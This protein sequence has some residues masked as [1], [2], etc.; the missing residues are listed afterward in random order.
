MFLRRT[1]ITNNNSK[2]FLYEAYK[3]SIK[4]GYIEE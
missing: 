1:N 3:Q 2:E 4:M